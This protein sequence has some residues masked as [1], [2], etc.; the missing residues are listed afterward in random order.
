M[1]LGVLFLGGIM[2]WLIQKEIFKGSFLLQ[3]GV[4]AAIVT[5]VT[6][7]LERR[8][9]FAC[10]IF[11]VVLYDA[12]RTMELKAYWDSGNQ[13]LD[14]YSGRPVSII[15]RKMAMEFLDIREK[16][17]RYVPYSS[18][19]RENGLLPV[20]SV[21]SMQIYNG[22]KTIEIRPAVLGIADAGL[23]EKK[24]YDLILHASMLEKRLVQ[25]TEK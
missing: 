15:S 4:A 11:P 3:A 1:Y 13:L 10:H 2:E 5:G 22:K 16:G 21:E 6:I 25:K 20:C 17:I 14:S 24:E 23:L 19:G 7:Y 8:E 18:L 12:G 9:Q